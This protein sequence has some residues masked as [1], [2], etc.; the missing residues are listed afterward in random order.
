VGTERREK[1]SLTR[2]DRSIFQN[3]IK[4]KFVIFFLIRAVNQGYEKLSDLL[5]FQTE[6]NLSRSDKLKYGEDGLEKGTRREGFV[7]MEEDG[8]FWQCKNI[9]F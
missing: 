3:R 6:I 8:Y 4:D 9:V 5:H 7:W 2:E 1:Q